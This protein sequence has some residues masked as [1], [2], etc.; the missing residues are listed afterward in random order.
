MFIRNIIL[1]QANRTNFYK[2][3]LI[4]ITLCS[5]LCPQ[6][7]IADNYYWVAGSGNWSELNHWATSS[8][9]SVF[10][11]SVPD[12][13][14]NVI[15][16]QNSFIETSNTVAID[17]ENAVCSNLTFLAINKNLSFDGTHELH[18][19][20]DLTL[21]PLLDFQF[22]GTI[23]FEAR[24]GNQV[25]TT[26]NKAFQCDINFLGLTCNWS[27]IGN[28]NCA[29]SVRAN[30]HFST[31]TFNYLQVGTDLIFSGN[32]TTSSINGDIS[33]GKDFY[34]LGAGSSSS[35]NGLQCRNFYIYDGNLDLNGNL[36]V[37][38]EI[39]LSGGTFN[40]N[41]KNIDSKNCLVTQNC[42]TNL[43]NSSIHISDRFLVSGNSSNLTSS[44]T[45]ILF[46]GGNDLLFS[47]ESVVNF[48]TISFNNKGTVNCSGSTIQSISF[49]D[50]GAITG[51]GNNLGTVNFQKNG[52]L[53]GS[54]QFT[55]LTL[56]SNYE[57]Q[58]Q[59][60]ETQTITGAFSASGNCQAYIIL[61]SSLDGTQAT[62]SK[63]S[64]TCNIDYALVQDINFTGGATF[65]SSAYVN[66]KNTTGLNGNILSDRT[67]YWI[68][69]SGNWSDA[70]NWSSISGGTGGECIPSP[71]DNVVFDVNSFPAPNQAVL[72]DAEQVFCNTMD[73]TLATNQPAFSNTEEN[74]TLHV[75][76]SYRLTQNMTNSF[77]GKIFFRSENTGNIIQSNNNT[78]NADIYFEEEGGDW[79]LADNLQMVNK[80]ILLDR[81]TFYSNGYEIVTNNLFSNKT[82]YNR[83]L[84][85]ENS[86]VYIHDTWNVVNELFSLSAANSHIYM[87]KLNAD[88]Q[89]GSNLIYQNISFTNPASNNATINGSLL[90]INQLYYEADGSFNCSESSVQNIVFKGDG[91]LNASDNLFVNAKFNAK[92]SFLFDNTFDV[93][94]L[95][96]GNI[97]TFKTD[98]TQAITTNLVANGDCNSP[99][100]MRSDVDGS[101]SYIHKLSTDLT[102][103][104]IIMKDIAAVSGVNYTAN[105]TTDLGNNP[106]WTINAVNSNDYYWVGGTGDWEDPTHWSFS[107]GGIGGVA[108]ACLPSQN[109]N[110]YFDDQS[111]S[112]DGE[113][114]SVNIEKINC[115]RMDW[116]QIDDHVIF[117]NSVGSELDVYGSFLLSSNLNWDFA[118]DISFKGTND[119]F[120]INT[121]GKQL[122]KNV[123]FIGENAEWEILSDLSVTKKIEL[124]QGN[125]ICHNQ[126]I[127][128]ATFLSNSASLSGL[129]VN[130]TMINLEDSWNTQQNFSFQGNNSRISLSKYSAAFNNNSSN[131]I[132]FN[133]IEL[134]DQRTSLISNNSSIKKLVV[135]EGKINGD[136]TTID[137]LFFNDK[138][139]VG[140][141]LT[142]GFG[143]FNEKSQILNNHQFGQIEFYGPT[144]VYM[145][146]T[147]QKAT[148]YNDATI[149]GDNTYDSLIFSPDHEY[150]LG[151]YRTQQV[152]NYIGLDGNSCFKIILKSS[153]SGAPAT[154]SMPAGTVEGYAVSLNSIHATGGAS[155]YAAGPSTNLGG[156]TGWIFGNPP[157]YIYGF[158]TD[159]I[160]MEGETAILSTSSFNTDANTQYN[161][162]TGNTSSSISTN[163]PGKYTVEV[164]YNSN[165]KQCSFTDEINIHFATI[166][167]A[168]C[169]ANGE[170]LIQSDPNE[171]YDY[172]WSTGST[173]ASITTLLPGEYSVE[174]TNTVSGKKAQR[175]FILDGPPELEAEFVINSR[176]SCIGTSDGELS[177]SISGGTPPYT[178]F[179]MDDSGITSL[180]RNNLAAG[181]YQ[182]NIADS[183][184]CQ[185]II[186]DAVV[187]EPDKME[188]EIIPLKNISCFGDKDAS[189]TFSATGGTP[190][191]T[192]EWNNGSN[193]NELYYLVPDQYSI[194]VTDANKCELLYDTI[195]IEQPKE[196]FAD[197]NIENPQY[198]D[199]EDGSIEVIPGG[200]TLPY[201]YYFT[202]IYGEKLVTTSDLVSGEY[203]L[204][205][206]DNNQCQLVD[207]VLLEADYDAKLIIPNTFTPNDDNKNDY[208]AIKSLSPI[209]YYSIS[210]HNRW[211]QK[212]FESNNI[213]NSWD[214]RYKGKVCSPG[215]YYYVIQYQNRDKIETRKGFVHLFN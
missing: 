7:L 162:S 126:T 66:I 132:S 55:N 141:T 199:S 90:T 124:R 203:I 167:H 8:G 84:N 146:N 136:N 182:L 135:Y 45:D 144:A 62:I 54:N 47:A 30:T 134:T 102:I 183:S 23:F 12:F 44:N 25:L 75:F 42:E 184:N 35:V 83:L 77:D 143:R 169:G 210:I 119:G 101:Q 123:T 191:Y 186:I 57:Y 43:S 67:L 38:N 176:T 181:T 33:V 154:I 194:V 190:P 17:V 157:G 211:G 192:C 26:E 201:S 145:N 72:I 73:W 129:D 212:L 198:Q 78:I 202:N 99:I 107:S 37:S 174:I 158:S 130:N 206:T 94:N 2:F 113:S 29:K 79:T 115:R 103:D 3:F 9:G 20:G 180:T 59:Q 125:I 97:Y 13:D 173:S 214:G 137:S 74:A 58:F 31:F 68:G 19:H 151:P 111:F 127:S 156:N 11:S 122:N 21:S 71:K 64:G 117:N 168:D 112:T 131:N 142:I 81:G 148:F 159:S 105:N 133:E 185:N 149:Y 166:R 53:N 82:D 49:A 170:I 70:S 93:L 179:W 177:A 213:N 187:T 171:N 87:E 95:T 65:T 163:E 1:N 91:T 207:T 5:F 116:S 189:I 172:L 155:F 104:Y 152:N 110:V 175:T 215:V 85:I 208:F 153:S 96:A 40:S 200:G 80:S 121:E 139:E 147:F 108:G 52:K 56:T 41:G 36:S 10:H 178:Q 196:L 32:N 109:D 28:L 98:A 22:S 161:W 50:D 120:Q 164:I 193:S 197:Y 76:G 24:N 150:S 4:L 48:H 60:G 27:I 18:V 140:G 15:F 88:M 51:N 16:D 100:T 89:A 61:K 118:G 204:H 86:E 188:M 69:G 14:D 138:A 195:S 92:G 63:S 39:Y 128:S 106:G 165:P 209:T 46:D 34:M 160:Y 114:V 6:N 205:L